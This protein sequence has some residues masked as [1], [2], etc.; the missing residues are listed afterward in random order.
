WLVP[1]APEAEADWGGP[2]QGAVD[3]PAIRLVGGK[4]G[5]RPRLRRVAEFLRLGAEILVTRSITRLDPANRELHLDGGDV[6]R[7]RTI[8]LACGVAWRRL[9]IEG[10]EEL[11]GKG[12]AYG[13]ARSEAPASHG[14]DVQIV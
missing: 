7:A 10:G 1:D 8:I 2:L 5:I 11:S 3:R 12:V 6:L 9:T 14:F 4:T 13:A